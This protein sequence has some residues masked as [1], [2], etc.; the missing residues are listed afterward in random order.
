MLF[1]L[2]R[3]KTDLRDISIKN[4]NVERVRT[5]KF[6]GIIFDDKMSWKDHINSVISKLNSCLGATRGAR[7][8][9]NKKSLFTIYHSLM[10]SHVNYC[11]ETWGPWEPRGNQ[12]ILRR[13]QAVINK[14]FRMIY[15]LDH[16]DS[17]RHILKCQNILNTFQNYDFQVLLMMH[18]AVNDKLPLPV[19]NCLTTFNP[20]F[21]FK[22]PRLKQTE[23]S[24]SFAGPRLWNSLPYEL[25]DE[26]DYNIFKGKLR[27]HILNR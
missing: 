9:L 14:F 15:F 18:R 11:T 8:F 13:L 12:V 23:K 4:E 16:T 22:T 2:S 3:A 7:P 6:L 19:L 27:V 10:Q 1:E 24:I 26:P 17:V 21:Y 20:F 25:V 5:Q